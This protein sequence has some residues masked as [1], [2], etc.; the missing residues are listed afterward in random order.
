MIKSRASSLVMPK[1][2]A[3]ILDITYK[4]MVRDVLQLDGSSIK[5]VGILKNVEM[6]L[7]ACLSRTIIQDIS[8]AKV[9]P[10]FFIHLSR[11]FTAQIGGYVASIWFYMFFT[12]RYGTKASLREAPLALNHIENYTPNPIN[13]NYTI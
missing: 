4:P 12:T 2:I 8:I 9:K 3:E 10:H 13:K 5:I 6:A 1:C 11:D 7:H